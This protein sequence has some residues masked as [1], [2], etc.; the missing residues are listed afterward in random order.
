MNEEKKP[1][2]VV[3]INLP[4]PGKPLMKGR[5]FVAQTRAVV[6]DGQ[7]LKG[8]EV[9]VLT[10]D[11][12]GIVEWRDDEENHEQKLE[13]MNKH[14]AKKNKGVSKL[15]IG[16]F[17]SRKEALKEMDK[18][19]VKA[20]AEEIASLKSDNESKDNELAELREKLAAAQKSSK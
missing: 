17:G 16:P 6:T 13:A 4:V 7:Q 8:E 18:Q 10:P 5:I 15:V 11:G 2:Q 19:R 9:V 3:F 12:F 20:P 14:M 1:K